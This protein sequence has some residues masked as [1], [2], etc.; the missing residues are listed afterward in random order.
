[1]LWQTVCC[2]FCD[3]RLALTFKL[4]ED[5]CLF[6]LLGLCGLIGERVRL[7]DGIEVDIVSNI[8]VGVSRVVKASHFDGAASF[9]SRKSSLN[10]HVPA[11]SLDWLQFTSRNG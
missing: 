11:S 9:V 1:M 10:Y 7:R 8:K 3:S 6:C 5:C 4:W 2:S